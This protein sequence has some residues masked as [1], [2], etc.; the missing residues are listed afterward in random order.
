M[1]VPFERQDLTEEQLEMFE[2]VAKYLSYDEFDDTK[3]LFENE[4]YLEKKSDGE[5]S[6]GSV[7]LRV[8]AGPKRSNIVCYTPGTNGGRS[9][10]TVVTK[11]AINNL[12]GDAVVPS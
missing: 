9:S 4:V 12:N 2:E 11:D 1:A 7:L 3:Y 8:L 10:L 5:P 6:V